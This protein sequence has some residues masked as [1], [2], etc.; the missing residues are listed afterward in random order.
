MIRS[1]RL[2]G[3]AL[4]IGAMSWAQQPSNSK[5]AVQTS[6]PCDKATTQ[7]EITNCTA[8]QATKAD[9]RLT[10]L[11]EKVQ[12]AIQ[13]KI[14]SDQGSP[15]QLYEQR[16]LARL[17]AAQLAWTHYRDAQCAAEEQQYEGGTIAPSVHAGCMKDLADRR[18][19]DLKK[20]YA[21][22]LRPK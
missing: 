2:T 9:A 3:I 11:Y 6:G 1:L 22:Y 19:D 15:L 10:A 5:P 17:K 14:A 7:E 12:K 8:D 4:V 20:T 13:V 18:I 16:A 21:I